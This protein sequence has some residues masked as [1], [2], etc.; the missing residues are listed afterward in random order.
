[1]I[2]DM[3]KYALV[4]FA[5]LV[6]V[7]AAQAEDSKCSLAPRHQH[8]STASSIGKA[9]VTQCVLDQLGEPHTAAERC[10]FWSDK[11]SWLEQQTPVW[12]FTLLLDRRT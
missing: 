11:S 5:V 6:A 9:C 4:F 8:L 1:M 3:K 12:D 7:W 10:V 2:F